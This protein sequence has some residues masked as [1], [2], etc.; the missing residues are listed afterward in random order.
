MEHQSNGSSA[1]LCHEAADMGLATSR[2]SYTS[3]QHPSKLTTLDCSQ[4]LHSS[5]VYS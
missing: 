1:G 5:I 2:S 3:A 4:R